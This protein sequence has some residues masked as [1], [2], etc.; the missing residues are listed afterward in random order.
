M[1][2]KKKTEEI[3]N[4]LPSTNK[5]LDPVGGGYEAA[6]KGKG[7]GKL[8]PLKDSPRK[9]EKSKRKDTGEDEDEVSPAKDD[10][11]K[12][13]NQ[14]LSYNPALQD[15]LKDDYPSPNKKKKKW[16]DSDDSLFDDHPEL[17]QALSPIMQE[18]SKQEQPPSSKKKDKEVK[19]KEDP[20]PQ[21][22]Q[23]DFESPRPALKSN[24]KEKEPEKTAAPSNNEIEDLLNEL[25]NEEED[26]AVEPSTRV[27]DQEEIGWMLGNMK[28][29][30]G[31]MKMKKTEKIISNKPLNKDEFSYFKKDPT[32]KQVEVVKPW[33]ETE[34]DLNLFNAA[35][36]PS[37]QSSK[38]SKVV[39]EFDFDF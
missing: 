19:K 12:A 34:E 23:E 30:G 2:L 18:S 15:D 3:L 36:K 6:V 7:L 1:A 39:D 5:T 14:P 21:L 20:V 22:P 24:R 37:K 27:D 10:R 16:K 13:K 38:P 11:S 26:R 31:E 35:S 8:Q 32:Q 25:D 28:M 33:I 4:K 17:K 9:E 29:D